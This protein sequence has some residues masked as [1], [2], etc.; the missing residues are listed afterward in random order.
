[1]FKILPA[2]KALQQCREIFLHANAEIGGKL[3]AEKRRH[4][5]DSG[6][7]EMLIVI[8]DDDKVLIQMTGLVEPFKSEARAQPPVTDNGHHLPWRSCESIRFNHAQRGGDGRS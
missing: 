6:I 4:G 3:L 7:N 8:E 5:A 2:R 1:M